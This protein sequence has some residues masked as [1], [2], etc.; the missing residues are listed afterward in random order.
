MPADDKAAL[1]DLLKAA[2]L[3]LEFARGSSLEELASNQMRL[4]AVLYQIIIVGEAARRLSPQV[5]QANP[6]VP[7]ADIIG[8]RSILVHEYDGVV[9]SEVWHVI[10]R[11]LN[12]LIPQL[13]TLLQNL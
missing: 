7:W 1:Q 5:R 13:E 12:Q 9:A 2:S 6:Q 8:M 4:S 10:Q 11:D 3:V